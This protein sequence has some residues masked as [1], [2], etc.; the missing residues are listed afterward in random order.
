MLRVDLIWRVMLKVH[1][2]AGQI[3][4]ALPNTGLTPRAAEKGGRARGLHPCEKKLLEGLAPL[5]LSVAVMES[6]A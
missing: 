1:L 3:A 2:T 5:K 6:L 4:T